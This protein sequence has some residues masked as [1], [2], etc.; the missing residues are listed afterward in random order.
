MQMRDLE[1]RLLEEREEKAV[2]AGE[3]AALMARLAKLK[4]AETDELREKAELQDAL[5]RSEE[6]R[7]E[8]SRA[9]IDFQME[10]NEAKQDWA[11]SKFALEQRILELESGRLE[12]HV[13]HED[14]AVLS[15]ERDSLVRH[16]KEAEDD[17]ARLKK[18]LDVERDAS[19]EALKEVRRLTQLQAALEAASAVAEANGS[20]MV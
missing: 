6:Q 12:H 5:V 9:L 4:D 13:R 3:K 10:T 19:A 8:V 14:H 1:A 20:A 17:V 15:D 16:L 2:L 18:A 7:L 11:N